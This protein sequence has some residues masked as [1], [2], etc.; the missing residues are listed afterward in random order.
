[1][2]RIKK[3]DTVEVI[4]GDDRGARNIVLRVLPKEN[5]VVVS[6]VNIVTKHQKPV[7]AGR[8]QTQAGRIQFEAPVHISNVMLVCPRCKA[9]T[10]VGYQ[11]ADDGGKVRICRKCGEA[12]D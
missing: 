9:A 12:I 8:S 6:K 4:A 3:G 7:R 10:R 2:N 1:M 11:V 5:R